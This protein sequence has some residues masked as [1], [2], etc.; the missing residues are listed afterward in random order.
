ML[1]FKRDQDFSIKIAHCFAIAVRK[2]DSAGGQADVVE[3]T[4]ELGG[5]YHPANYVF[6]F[7]GNSRSFLNARAGFCPQMEA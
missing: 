4:G 2:I 1:C 5:G 3:N 7:T 6:R